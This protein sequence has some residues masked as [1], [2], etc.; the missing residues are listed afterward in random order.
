MTIMRY[1]VDTHT[2]IWFLEDNP[3]LGSNAKAILTDATSQLQ[4]FSD[5]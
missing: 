5:E 2:I 1:V 3:R 4:Q